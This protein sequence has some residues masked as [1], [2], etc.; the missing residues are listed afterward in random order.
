MTAH[1]S[2]QAELAPVLCSIMPCVH[3]RSTHPVVVTS[4]YMMVP[5]A[6]PPPPFPGRASCKGL[7][8]LR[9]C[10]TCEPAM[11]SISSPA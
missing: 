5:H 10:G 11:A 3:H 9:I 2:S 1:C 7:P 6:Q 4:A 8:S